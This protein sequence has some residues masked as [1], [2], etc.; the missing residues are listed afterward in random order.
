MYW[1]GVSVALGRHWGTVRPS[2]S[3]R[4][5]N[6]EPVLKAVVWTVDVSLKAAAPRITS[7]KRAVFDVPSAI[8][9]ILQPWSTLPA[10]GLG[11]AKIPSSDRPFQVTPPR[12]AAPPTQ[13][14]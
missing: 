2:A 6:V 11:I 9:L 10:G 13:T 1:M 5:A 4:A 14:A 7:A 8:S 3:C 12:K